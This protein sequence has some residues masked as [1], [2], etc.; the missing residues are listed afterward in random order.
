MKLANQNAIVMVDDDEIDV[1]LMKRSL[2]LS[3]LTND[4]RAFYS[5]EDFLAYIETVVEGTEAMPAIVFLD[6]NMPG[7][8]GFEVLARVRQYDELATLPVITIL[9]HSDSQQDMLQAKALGA[10]FTQKFDGRRAALSFLES[11]V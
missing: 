2:E 5:G 6:V 10:E 1:R 4:F 11:L 8:T 9:T 3:T 7:M